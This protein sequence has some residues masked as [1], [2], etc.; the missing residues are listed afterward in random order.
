M[1]ST[2]IP[3]STIHAH[4]RNRSLGCRC[5]REDEVPQRAEQGPEQVAD[6]EAHRADGRLPSRA[7]RHHARVQRSATR[8]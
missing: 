8:R 5:A 1:A 2:A 4:Q 6:A 7:A 3:A